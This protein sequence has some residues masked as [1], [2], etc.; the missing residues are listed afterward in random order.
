[1]ADPRIPVVVAAPPMRTGGTE[2]HLL[3]I[4]P[5]L[6]KEGFAITVVLLGGGGALE[7]KL[8]EAPVTVVTPAVERER[9]WRTAAQALAI[10]D[11]VR[12]TGASVVHAFLSEPYLAAA[13][14]LSLPGSGRPALIHGRRSEAFYAKGRPFAARAERLAHRAAYR[15]V[16]NSAAV[17]QELVAESGAPEKVVVIH[18]G[19]PLLG[20]IAD[21]ERQAA[22]RVFG[23]G[24]APLVLSLVANFHAYKG[25]LDL[26]EALVIARDALPAGWRLLLAGRDGGVLAGL[27][28]VT[29][30]W[31]LSENLVFAGEWPGSREPYAAAD[32]G[33]LVSHTEGF[34]NSLIEGM[35]A[36]LP[37]VATAVGGNPDAVTDGRTGLLVPARD[38]SAL[39]AALVRL[40]GDPALRRRLGDAAAAEAAERFSLAACVDAYAR[41]WREAATR[42]LPPA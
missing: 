1:M 40:G 9:P 31:G 4:L 8:R 37:M 14:V 42:P 35:A 15:L 27:R 36:G 24:D 5:A 6:A 26:L 30:T 16:G 2:Q 10:R 38:P 33:L 19:I 22:R 7:A 29:E 34:S 39:A 41:L 25:H 23:V 18:N 11:A 13:A 21:A 17:A 32:I 20:P 3:H 12:R 28:F